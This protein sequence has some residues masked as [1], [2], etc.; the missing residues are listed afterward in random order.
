MLEE[1]LPEGTA[2][3]ASVLS[4]WA[5]MDQFYLVGGTALTLHLGHRRSRDLD[6]FTR[7]PLTELPPLPGLD[8]CLVQFGH[9]ETEL[10]V[11]HQLQ[12]KLDNVS[13]ILLAY[14]FAHSF[15]LQTWRGLAIAD[16]RDVAVQ[17]VYAVVRRAQTRDYLDLHAI[18]TK[19]ILSFDEVI[20]LAQDTYRDEFSKRM[21]LQ[22]L[23]YIKDLKDVDDALSLL[24]LPESLDTI[25]SD[26]D[27]QVK[28]WMAHHFRRHTQGLQP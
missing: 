14:P 18:L 27:N 10:A 2:D 19:G 6:F 25:V 16:P 4:R 20:N 17:K 28:N 1:V 11:T 15:D 3:V 9:V 8:D 13:V 26:L 12:W 22:Q 7:E 24:V 5:A 21:F 23:T